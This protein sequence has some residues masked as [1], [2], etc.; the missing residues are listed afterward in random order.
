MK[1][2]TKNPK[3]ME[4]DL[5]YIDSNILHKIITK[6]SLQNSINKLVSSLITIILM[7]KGD[8]QR[9]LLLCNSGDSRDSCPPSKMDSAKGVTSENCYLQER[10]RRF[11]E[12]QGKI[13]LLYKPCMC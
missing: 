5:D 13:Y 10:V 12:F 6:E 9:H 7:K 8:H 1:L 3:E 11:L 4:W 2:F